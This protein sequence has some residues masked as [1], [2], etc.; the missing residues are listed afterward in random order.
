MFHFWLKIRASKYIQALDCSCVSKG[1]HKR[2]SQLHSQID[3]TGF[4]SD[5]GFGKRASTPDKRVCIVHDHPSGII[6][7]Q[8]CRYSATFIEGPTICRNQLWYVISM[9]TSKKI[10]THCGGSGGRQTADFQLSYQDW[11]FSVQLHKTCF[12]E[13]CSLKVT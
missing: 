1:G 7:D 10:K 8:S 13:H 9:G 6:V 11:V 2:Q 4:T 12:T 5:R 3:L